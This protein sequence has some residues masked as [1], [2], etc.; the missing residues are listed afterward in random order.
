M[1]DD[2]RQIP[3]I[4]VTERMSTVDGSDGVTDAML[5]G[6]TVAGLSAGMPIVGLYVPG[7]DARMQL[8]M[9]RRTVK[10]AVI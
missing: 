10:R 3:G 8:R 4:R 6:A 7:P 2:D 5:C 9:K 1:T